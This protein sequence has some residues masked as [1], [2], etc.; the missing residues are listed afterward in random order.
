V[1]YVPKQ[2]KERGILLDRKEAVSLYSELVAHGLVTPSFV[3]IEQRKP[4]NHQL[5][6]K[7]NYDFLLVSAFVH[8]KKLIVEEDKAKE[9]ILVFKQ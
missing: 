5:K 7:G 9:C 6:I 2:F 3:V 4:D 8:S 1:L